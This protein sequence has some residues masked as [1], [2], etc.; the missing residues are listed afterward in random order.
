MDLVQLNWSIPSGPNVT[1]RSEVRIA[2]TIERSGSF[3]AFD[4][5]ELADLEVFNTAAAAALRASAPLPALPED[6]P[7]SNLSAVFV[8]AYH[9]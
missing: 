7:A 4:V 9:D 1:G 6:F 5:T 3:S 8:F 2:V